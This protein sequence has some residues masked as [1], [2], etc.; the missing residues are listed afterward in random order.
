MWGNTTMRGRHSPIDALTRLASVDD[1]EQRRTSW[2]Q[3]LAALGEYGR[4]E[5]PPPLDGLPPGLLL[6]AAQVALDSGL[7]EDLDW[8]APER[9]AVAL[10]ELTGALPPGRERT[11][12]GRR[13]FSRLYQGTAS[14]FAAVATRMAIHSSKRLDIPALQARVHLLY[15]LPA[16]SSVNA[17]ALA[18]T[19]IARRESFETWVAEP[20]QST[21]PSRRM[22][23]ILLERAAREIVRSSE[24]GDS[25]PLLRFQHPSVQNSYR[26]LLADREPLVWRHAAIARGLLSAVDSRLREEIDLELDPSLSP[27][28][29]RR[30]VVSL[31]A[32]LVKDPETTLPQC[33]SLLRS[34]LFE[35]HPAI[36]STLL[37]GLG[38]VIDAEPELARELLDFLSWVDRNDVAQDLAGLLRDVHN[39]SFGRP[40]ALR[41][42]NALLDRLP[43]ADADSRVV[44]EL[45]AREL[46]SERHDDSSIWGGVRT[47]LIAFETT[48]AEA[49]YHAASEALTRSYSVLDQLESHGMG[50]LSPE[51]YRLLMD[52]DSG[53][54]ENA[55][56]YDLLLLGRRPGDTNAS[57]VEMERLYDRLGSWLLAQGPRSQGAESADSAVQRQ[58][59]LALLHLIDV[60][61]STRSGSEHVAARVAWRIRRSIHTLLGHLSTEAFSPLHRVFCAALARSYDAAIREGVADVSDLLLLTIQALQHSTSVSAIVDAST[62][63]EVRQTLQAYAD[64][65][66]RAPT[67]RAFERSDGQA[68]D[69]VSSHIAKLGAGIPLSCSYRGEALRQTLLR[70]GHCLDDLE[71]ARSLG[72]LLDGG[73]HD[74]AELERACLDLH[75]LQQAA[76]VRL[77]GEDARTPPAGPSH[78]ARLIQVA[79][80]SGERPSSEMLTDTIQ[81]L[82]T[83]LPAALAQ[84]LIERL[85]RLERLKIEP[86]TDVPSRRPLHNALPDW[87][88]P[89]RTIGSFYVVQSLGAGGASSVFVARRVEAR[90]QSNAE[91]Y[92]LKVPKYDATVARSLSE[93]EFLDMFRQEAGAL[94]ALPKHP[95][96]ARFVNFDAEARPKPILVMELIPGNSLERVVRKGLLTVKTAFQFLDGILL[97]L[98]AMHSAG[99]GHL[100][101]KPANVI[102][103]DEKTAVLVDFGLSG[104]HIRPGCGTLEYCAPEVLGVDPDSYTASPAATDVYAFACLAFETLTTK[105]LFDGKDEAAIISQHIDHDGWPKRLADFARTDGCRDL[106]MLLAR[107]LRRDAKMRPSGREVRRAL[108]LP[109]HDLEAR[110]WP[111]PMSRRELPPSEMPVPLVAGRVAKKAV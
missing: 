90:H 25:G 99:L 75:Q 102:L 105:Y 88:L 93:Q 110:D 98:E 82:C 61:T 69:V 1:S 91:L 7:I 95:H 80:S 55:R 19:L 31:V 30:A 81:A 35:R 37:W 11:A 76:S 17:D 48:G 43:Q 101:V 29:W 32:C 89:R 53:V 111:L 78:L 18:L 70:I 21:L 77:L 63:A 5:R 74:I 92:A 56:L 47:A 94:L 44:L 106:A 83:N 41:M 42:K 68:P 15:S 27:T 96:L 58:K 62:T 33:K 45:L 51:A 71:S 72:D 73:P 4:V 34:E 50:A 8:A 28:E 97:G 20:A 39:P 24:A 2:R 3:A 85:T 107:C 57:V 67:S 14:T 66:D 38:P 49:A 6:R 46:A 22:A 54:L 65:L 23:A 59:W 86:T 40:A 36:L 79:V 13:A 84:P 26:T 60:E 16:G 104:R 100:D 108:S 64:F 87:L 103:R 52:L 9:A 10:Y 109:A 12:L